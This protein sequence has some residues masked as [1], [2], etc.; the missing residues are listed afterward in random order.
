MDTPLISLESLRA[1]PAWLVLACVGVLAGGGLFLLAKPLKWG[2]YALLAGVFI[3]I[4]GAAAT[5]LAG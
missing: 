5:W 4:L 2:L 1:Y 3:A